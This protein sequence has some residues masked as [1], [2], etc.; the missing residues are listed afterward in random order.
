[1]TDSANDPC[2]NVATGDA[3]E[4]S[5][6]RVYDAPPEKVYRAWTDP[7]LLAQWFVPQPWRISKV[8]HE[9]R[10]GGRALVVMQDPDGNEY[11]NDGVFLE[12]VPNRKLVTTNA[13]TPGWQPA[14]P[15]PI[16]MIALV[17]LEPEGAGQAPYTPVPPPP[18]APRPDPQPTKMIATVPFDPE[19]AGQTRYPARA[20][21]WNAADRATHE[22]MGFHEGGGICA[23]QL[24]ARLARI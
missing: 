12:V 6:T 4:L 11:P 16:K 20:L 3:H 23:D 1:M 21:H 8:D 9:L 19:G 15:P 24:G 5:L 18:G 10:P 13:F 22:Q 17:T 14:A 7:A 2:R